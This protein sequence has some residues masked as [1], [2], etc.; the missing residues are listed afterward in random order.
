MII[1]GN[2]SIII[3]PITILCQEMHQK[4]EYNTIYAE[5]VEP[6]IKLTFQLDPEY[7]IGWDPAKSKRTTNHYLLSYIYWLLKWNCTFA[8]SLLRNK[9]SF[10]IYHRLWQDDIFFCQ[11]IYFLNEWLMHWLNYNCWNSLRSTMIPMHNFLVIKYV[12]FTTAH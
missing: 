11:H 1:K 4:S 7:V 3:N 9:P 10:S 8:T 2:L 12:C 6:A 5:N